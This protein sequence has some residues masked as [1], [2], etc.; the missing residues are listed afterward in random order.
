[1]E[2]EFRV[3]NI[4]PSTVQRAAQ[5]TQE[6]PL[7]AY[8]AIQ[9]AVGLSVGD[10]LKTSG[11]ALVFVT[12]DKTLLQAARAEGLVA[13]NPFDHS[14]MDGPTQQVDLNSSSDALSANE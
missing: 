1:M 12:S 2:R 13:E 10:A 6:H 3:V 14:N 5:L 4:S 7:K 11:L 8:D 9:L